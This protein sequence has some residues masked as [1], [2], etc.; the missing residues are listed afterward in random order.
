M[1]KANYYM[2]EAHA[3]QESK[4][5]CGESHSCCGESSYAIATKQRATLK[6]VGRDPRHNSRV[7]ARVQK[8]TP[9]HPRSPRVLVWLEGYTLLYW[10]STGIDEICV[11]IRDRRSEPRVKRETEIGEDCGGFPL[12]W[13]FSGTPRVRGDSL[14]RRFPRSRPSE[15]CLCMGCIHPRNHSKCEPYMSSLPRVEAF[16]PSE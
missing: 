6:S 16:L 12:N 11:E 15:R 10:H 14:I 2:M 3:V 8:P 4:V 9:V 1:M 7:C 5:E 13:L